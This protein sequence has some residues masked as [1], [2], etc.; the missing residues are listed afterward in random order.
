MH[1]SVADSTT[2]TVAA[3]DSESCSSS[4]N[5]DKK[6]DHITSVLRFSHWLPVCQIID[7]KILLLVYKALNGFGL[8]Y[9]SDLLLHYEPSRPLWSSSTGLLSVPGV[10]IKHGET[11][12]SYYGS[13]LKQTPRKLQVCSN[14]KTEDLLICHCFSLKQF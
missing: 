7:F 3:A 2:V 10:R 5:K 9:I 13:H 6:V 4:P 12:F 14:S 8:Q 1:L 11:V